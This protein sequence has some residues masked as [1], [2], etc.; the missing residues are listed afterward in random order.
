MLLIAIKVVEGTLRSFQ[1]S[2]SRPRL[3]N[4]IPGVIKE[5]LNYLVGGP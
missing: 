1:C 3:F 5:L 2:S 4:E